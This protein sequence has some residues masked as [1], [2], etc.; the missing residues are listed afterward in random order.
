MLMQKIL[1]WTSGWV[2]G[3][4]LGL[5]MITFAVWGVNFNSQNAII[6]VGYVNDEEITLKQFQRV[7]N[8][9]RAQTRQYTGTSILTSEQ[10]DQLEKRALDNLVESKVL[11]QATVGYGSYINDI[12]LKTSIQEIEMFASEDGFDIDLYKNRIISAGMNIAEFEQQVRLELL[13]NQF[14]KVVEDSAFVLDQES[15]RLTQ[16]DKQIRDLQFILLPADALK[17]SIEVETTA[18]EEFYNSSDLGLFYPEKV[19]I[20]YIN[21]SVESLAAE[22]TVTEESL[23]T[24][25]A[26]NKDK[27]DEK[28]E[29]KLHMIDIKLAPDATDEIVNEVTAKA[30][31]IRSSIL[32]GTS[33]TDIAKN[34]KN[35]ELEISVTE[36]GYIAKGLLPVAIDEKVFSI[37]EG[38]LSEVEKTE[39]GLHIFEVSEIK[40]GIKNTLV[41]VRESVENDYKAL[42]A[43]N[44]Y[45]DLAEQLVTLVYEHPDTLEIAA[46]VI[47]IN[48]QESDFFSRKDV[49]GVL[50]DPKVIATAF[51]EETI[52]SGINSEAIKISDEHLVVLRVLEYLSPQKKKLADVEQEI[53]KRVQ[54]ERA[55]EMQRKKGLEILVQL[56][57]GK[58]IAEVAEIFDFEWTDATAV[59]RNDISVNRKILREAF[60]L[61]KNVENL[62]AFGSTEI[63]KEDYAVFLVKNV[64]IPEELLDEDVAQSKAQLQQSIVSSEWFS[65]IDVLVEQADININSS[66]SS[67]QSN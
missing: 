26:D 9:I 4:I 3:V 33:F 42:S 35:Q 16:I 54:A 51:L 57:Q 63:G 6:N 32:A 49:S 28:E 52:K 24:Y 10:E 58:D 50:A 7:Y 56:K 66:Y 59:N 13:S 34:Y 45:Y 43:K 62:P 44:K 27:Y 30:T 2:A 46:E 25:Y 47:G 15:I 67:L 48:V 29:R 60:K 37:A 53:I 31:E 18:V 5:V 21:L 40:R 39:K 65:M 12:K 38:E 23:L 14:R 41:H 17:D 55:S 61:T 22:I 8:N 64:S 19:K 36:H 11:A 20:A 1:H